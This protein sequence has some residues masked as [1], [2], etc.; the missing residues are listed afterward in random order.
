MDEGVNSFELDITDSESLVRTLRKPLLLS[1]TQIR[2]I[3]ASID[4]NLF[5]YHGYITRTEKFLE[6]L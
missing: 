5:D 4:S 1:K 6:S 2:S 3:K